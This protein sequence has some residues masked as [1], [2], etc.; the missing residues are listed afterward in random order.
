MTQEEKQL[1][2]KDISARLPYGTKIHIIGEGGEEIDA[3]LTTSTIDYFES[4]TVQPYLCPMSSMTEEEK[5]Q[6]KI[7]ICP[8]G[9]GSFNKEGLIIPGTHYG[10]LI[11]YA[12]MEDI[13]SWLREKHFDYHGLIEKGLALEAPKGMYKE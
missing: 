3:D 4:W 10:D 1:L 5:K 9:T 7:K 2:L 13:L 8:D 11:H 12:F 6:L